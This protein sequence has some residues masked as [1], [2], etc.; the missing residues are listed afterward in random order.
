MTKLDEIGCPIS[1]SIDVY[2]SSKNPETLECHS[3]LFC[4]LS[5]P[6][7]FK[8][9]QYQANHVNSE[10]MTPKL[11]ETFVKEEKPLKL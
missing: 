11:E 7:S 10:A 5:Q 9:V 2:E 3:S 1:S 4:A 8:L 6:K